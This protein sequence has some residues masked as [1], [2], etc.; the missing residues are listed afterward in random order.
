MFIEN[1]LEMLL[2]NKNIFTQ[3]ITYLPSTI[4]LHTS[5]SILNVHFFPIK[6]LKFP[7]SFCKAMFKGME[8]LSGLQ[9][10]KIKFMFYSYKNAKE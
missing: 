2:N 1:C 10:R 8:H 6:T 3:N 9:R 4:I 5:S 7:I